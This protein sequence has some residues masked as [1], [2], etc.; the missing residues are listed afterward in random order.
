MKALVGII[1]LVLFLGFYF[2]IG[3]MWWKIVKRTGYHGALGL[4]MLIPIANIIMMAI[5]AFREWPI[6]KDLMQIGEGKMAPQ[7]TLP[8]PLIVVIVIAAVIP[9]MALMAAIAIPNLLRAKLV[10]NQSAAQVTVRTISTAIES[11]ATA[12]NGNY[13]TDEYELRYTTAPYLTNSYNNKTVQGYS[14]TLNL[15]SNGYEIIARPSECEV[16][17]AKVFIAETG[18]RLFE[19][20]CK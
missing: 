5:L 2:L 7:K 18:G 19:R 4:L 11:Y 9:I 8:A 12:N 16:T 20:D 6:Y 17:G 3:L 14:Y 10:A 13:P 15:N 1:G